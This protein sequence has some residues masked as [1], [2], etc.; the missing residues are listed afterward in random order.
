MKEPCHTNM[1]NLLGIVWVK[2]KKACIVVA[3]STVCKLLETLKFDLV[4]FGDN[5]S[6][7]NPNHTLFPKGQLFLIVAV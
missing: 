4:S 5:L 3:I 1:N 7:C 6:S 2:N